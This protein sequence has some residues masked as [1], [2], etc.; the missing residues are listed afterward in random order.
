MTDYSVKFTDTGKQPILVE[1]DTEQSQGTDILLFGRSFLEYGEQLNENL[2]RLLENFACPE[3]IVGGKSRPD[4]TQAD[5]TLTE[6]VEGQLWFNTTKKCLFQWDGSLWLKLSVSSDYAANWGQITDGQ[7]LPRPIGLD[8]Y[9]FPYSECIWIVS[10][11]GH[12]GRFDYMAC[13]TD[14]SAN[15]IMKYRLLGTSALTSGAANYLIVG[16]KGNANQGTYGIAP[17]GITPTPTPT[18]GSSP[19]PTPAASPEVSPSPQ[20]TVSPTRSP[21]PTPTRAATPT[22]TPAPSVTP[23]PRPALSIQVV[24]SARGGS[25]SESLSLCDISDYYATRD[26]G[27]IGCSTSFDMCA[28]NACAPEPGTYAGG[29]DAV[30]AEVGITVS[31]GVAP[32]TVRFKDFTAASGYGE[33]QASG[34][35]LYIGGS[36]GFSTLPSGVVYTLVIN[37]NGGSVNGIAISASCGTGRYTLTGSFTVEVTDAIGAVRTATYPYT[38]RRTNR[39]DGM[40]LGFESGDTNW[41]KGAG[42]AINTSGDKFSG[43]WSATFSGG[44]AQSQINNQTLLP[45]QPNEA[46]TVSCQVQQGAASAG[47]ASGQVLLHFYNSAGGLIQTVGGNVVNSGSGGAW[48]GSTCAAYAPAGAAQVT[49]G[50]QFWKSSGNQMWLDAFTFTR[51]YFPPGSGGGGGGGGGGSGPGCVTTASYILGSGVASFVQVGDQLDVID[52]VSYAMGK[53][54]V[55]KADV[56]VQACVRIT[57]ES[58]VVLECSTTAPIANANGEQV[59]APQLLGETVPVYIDGL[60]VNEKVVSVEDIGEQE[61]MFITAE[62]NFFLAGAEENRYFFHHNAKQI[63]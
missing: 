18:A 34:D 56:E 23:S 55:S 16:I 29:G 7:Q 22:P 5:A 25:F 1:Q 10:P 4:T 37:A 62:N 15:V 60:I 58:G 31:G 14:P 40:N 17:P 24:D 19:T 38:V 3:I 51:G 45:V 50:A 36:G 35:C 53:G 63:E 20:V 26:Y 6:P 52:P 57:S 54:L 2:L 32:Y 43:G 13:T 12:A 59:L 61:V 21:T 44:S 46:V 27:M 28:V 48:G 49:V 33:F 39:I 8:G 47:A 11:A 41:S 9:V 42:W 30:G